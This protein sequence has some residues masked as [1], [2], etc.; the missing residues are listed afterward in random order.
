MN[1]AEQIYIHAFQKAYEDDIP[2][3]LTTEQIQF[4]LDRAEEYRGIDESYALLV[5][6]IP[7]RGF[8]HGNIAIVDK[9]HNVNEQLFQLFIKEVRHE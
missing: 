4:M 6:I 1:V 2:F 5:R 3:F 7:E 8:V 9:W